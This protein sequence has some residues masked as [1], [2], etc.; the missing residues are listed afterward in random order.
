MGE[1]QAVDLE[2]SLVSIGIKLKNCFLPPRP[3]SPLFLLSF[4]TDFSVPSTEPVA[5]ESGPLLF[6]WNGEAWCF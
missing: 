3:P 2:F 5:S 1:A 4:H 6:W